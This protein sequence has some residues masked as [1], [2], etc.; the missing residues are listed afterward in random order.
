MPL[1]CEYLFKSCIFVNLYLLTVQA[2]CGRY[3]YGIGALKLNAQN[4]HQFSA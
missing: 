3:K 1:K 2:I 4:G